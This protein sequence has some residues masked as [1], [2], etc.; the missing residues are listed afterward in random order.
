MILQS[1]TFW[2]L[3]IVSASIY[4]LLPLKCR[5]GFLAIASY[6]YLV[7]LEPVVVT[8]LIAWGLFFFY[9]T[10]HAMAAKRTSRLIL[11]GLILAILGYLAYYKYLPQL[12]SF[13]PILDLLKSPVIPLGISYFTF[14]L[15]HYALEVVRGNITD[16]SLQRFFCYI[17]LYPIFSAGPIERFDHFLANRDETWQLQSAVDGVTR[18]AHGLVKIFVIGQL[19]IAQLLQPLVTSGNVAT[20]QDLIS[21]LN[22]LKTYEV[23]GYLALAFLYAYMDFS[24]YSDI[25]IGAS[26]LYGFRIMENFN[27]PIAACNITEFWR[28]W[29]MTLVGWCQS[30]VYLPTIGLTRRPYVAVYCTFIAM[31]LWHGGLWNWLF[32]GLYHATGVSFYLTWGRIKRSRGWHAVGSGRLRYAGIPFTFAFVTGSYA[33]STT[34]GQG[35]WTS[36]RVFAKLLGIDLG[37]NPLL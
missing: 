8:V 35:G 36:L 10:P 34:V 29:H 13:F 6:A 16:R 28:R 37:V 25:A 19:V 32:W 12:S 24:A 20:V 2:L 33:F 3:L 30:Y 4:W 11:P 23:W 22:G 26:R 5:D 15:I 9:L 17:F 1:P 31:G 27:F 7:S 14:K 21:Q 18:I